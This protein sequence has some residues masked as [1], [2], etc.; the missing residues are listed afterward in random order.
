MEL[1]PVLRY[2]DLVLAGCTVPEEQQLAYA[3]L[4]LAGEAGEVAN[5]LG[6]VLYHEKPLDKIYLA[7]ELGDTLWYLTLAARQCD[8]DLHGLACQN[9]YK[10]HKRHGESKYPNPF[11]DV[12]VRL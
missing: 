11:T 1:A 12:V 4:K 10:L 5:Y 9:I 8:T 7:E 6:K 3:G 2:S